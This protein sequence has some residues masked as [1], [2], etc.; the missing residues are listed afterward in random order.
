MNRFVRLVTLL[1]I[2]LAASIGAGAPVL[3]QDDGGRGDLRFVV[4]S[5]GQASD[6]FWSVVQN[7]VNQAAEDM[8]VQVEYQAPDTF[9]MVEMSQLIDAAVASQPD[10]LVVSIPDADA[11]GESIQAAVEAGIP[12]I[13][14]NSGSDVAAEFGLLTHVG[15]TE[16]EAGLGAGQRMGEAGGVHP[17]F[18]KHGGG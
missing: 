11:L 14:I 3:G 9:D 6:P 7:G 8:G 18:A 1:A 13:S 4:V 10:G 15:Q 16:Y 17:T 2:A 5:H 12:G